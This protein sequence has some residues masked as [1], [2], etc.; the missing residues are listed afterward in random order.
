[1]KPNSH[2]INTA[3]VLAF[4]VISSASIAADVAFVGVQSGTDFSR[5]GGAGRYVLAP[6]ADVAGTPATG[7]SLMAQG[8]VVHK[9]EFLAGQPPVL[10]DAKWVN[11]KG[12]PEVVPPGGGD[13]V[14][15]GGLSATMNG[16]GEVEGL[17][18]RAVEMLSFKLVSNVKFRLGVMIDAFND[19]GAFAPDFVGIRDDASDKT[20][21][22][23]DV[24]R[25]DDTP[26][27][28]LFDIDGRAGVTYTLELHRAARAEGQP[29]TG[30]SALTFDV[31]SAGKELPGVE[32]SDASIGGFQRAGE[33]FKDYYVYKDGDTFHLFY[34][35]GNA[36]P[37]QDWRTPEN[38]KAFGHATSKDLREW[39]HHP[40]VLEV[41]PGTWE[42]EVVSAP[43]IL[44]HDG[45]Y[46]M[47]YTGFDN[48]WTGMQT[49][50][51]A[52]S[53]D[54]FE[55]KRHPRN[56]VYRAPEWALTNPNG[57]ENCRDAHIIR[58]NDEFLMYTMV[59]TKKQDGAIA[60]ASSKDAV[61]WKDL[62][63]AVIAF[64]EPESPRVFDHNGVYY[65]FAS[66]GHGRVLLKTRDPKSNKWEEVPFNWPTNS[67]DA[68]SQHWLGIWSGWEVLEHEGETVFSA[69]YW[70]PN[71]GF[72]S[73][74]KVR[75]E[76]E[77]PVV[78]YEK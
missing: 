63:P 38:E 72:I 62:G 33:Y 39:K 52:T 5:F 67:K 58:H 46:Y 71:G 10:A 2:L 9:P 77:I 54:L 76:G 3:T 64:K 18:T 23:R 47:I 48:R 21:F 75:W 30:L 73:F 51:L 61:E 50:G 74:W 27:L 78:I 49:V 57:W 24:V 8:T 34:N 16:K 11:F 66:S 32:T 59:L 65:M 22:S 1:M 13:K 28:L 7:G 15:I 29:I 25:R 41:V 12:Y 68:A 53:K 4:A 26:D 31:K 43:S 70:K 36:G 44:K 60:L 20:V 69:F 45:I 17:E 35:V 14:R 37:V 42:G 40:R 19:R 56:P 55:W 6:G